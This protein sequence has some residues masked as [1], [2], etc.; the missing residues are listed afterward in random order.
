MT[1]ASSPPA[2]ISRDQ[3]RIL[4]R[5]KAAPSWPRWWF[6]APQQPAPSAITTS[7]PCRV[8]SRI[9]ASLIC[10]AKN[11]LRASRQQGDASGSR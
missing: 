1:M 9:V 6:K 11:L 3:A 8:S 5:A 2:S 4:A 7:Q 10:G